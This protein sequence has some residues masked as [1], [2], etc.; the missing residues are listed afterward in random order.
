MLFIASMQ[1]P[2]RNRH[3]TASRTDRTTS[4]ELAAPQVAMFPQHRRLRPGLTRPCTSTDVGLNN[5]IKHKPGGSNWPPRPAVRPTRRQKTS[6]P[7]SAGLE[8]TQCYPK[9]K[10]AP[11]HVSGDAVRSDRSSSNG[12]APKNGQN[13]KI[14][15]SRKKHRSSAPNSQSARLTSPN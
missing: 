2:P 7:A 10:P 13:A 12:S 5:E 9:T 3:R 6:R 1:Q 8:K 11:S 14:T 15:R 4:F